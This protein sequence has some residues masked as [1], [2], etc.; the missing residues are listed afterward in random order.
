LRRRWVD[1]V[2]WEKEYK[3]KLVSVE[4]AAAFIKSNDRICSATVASI[5]TDLL[6][7]IG[8][9]WTELENVT[10][11]SQIALYPFDFFK[12]E[13]K[14]H[15]KYHVMFM[16][17]L[18]RKY[19]P[20][21][22]MDITSYNF[23]RSDWLVKNRMKAN[24]FVSEVSPPDENGNMSLGPLGGMFGK[25]ASEYAD[26]VILQVNKKTPYVYGAETS[27]INIRDVDYICESDRDLAV[28]PQPPVA[29]EETKIASHIIPYI[30]DGSTIQIGLGGV[31]NAVG[32]FLEDHKDLG[33]HTEM[34][35]DSL[36]HLAEKGVI[37]GSKKSIHKGEMII[38]FGLG[39]RKLY[40]FMH[41]N[42][43]VKSYPV[44]YVNDPYVIGKNK[45]FVSINS[46]LAC[47]LT[48]QVGSESIGF[49]QFSCTGGQLDFVRGA[50]LAEDGKSFL[51]MNSTARKKDGTVVSKI[52]ASLP[53]GTVVTTPRTD[54]HYVVTEYGVADL[55]ER[56]I[57][58]R[59]KA[60][61]NIAHPDFRDEL[62]RQA[63]EYGI[64]FA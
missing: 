29:E 46:C 6:I 5:P 61:V 60:L 14:G 62:A 20:E 11:I 38:A 53:P 2:D 49:H 54:V 37:N 47:D 48:G 44:Y 19:Y 4:A 27:F 40:D 42:E 59:V 13:Y 8:K 1:F 30:E 56:S 21:G 63:R 22:N 7:A 31:A 28:L 18:E 39:S 9:R 17:A 3:Q 34:L 57:A 64:I 16:G 52:T 26:T 36:V 15:I 32:F 45:K 41:K 25:I 50:S 33:V 43:R 55:R 51:C 12:K 23:S 10:I 24:V 35:T 58:E